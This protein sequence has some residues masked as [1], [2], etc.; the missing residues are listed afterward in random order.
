MRVRL[1]MGLHHAIS[2]AQIKKIF[3]FI[4]SFSYSFWLGK[5][6]PFLLPYDNIHIHLFSSE[7]SQPNILAPLT[8]G[9]IILIF[10]ES[11]EPQDRHNDLPHSQEAEAIIV[12][13]VGVSHPV[14]AG[15]V[16]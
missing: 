14:V 3:L 2:L 10:Q 5:R 11:K 13:S 6:I 12:R 1:N 7:G 16:P 8:S 15:A 9:N 4:F